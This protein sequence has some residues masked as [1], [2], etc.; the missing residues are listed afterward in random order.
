MVI[1]GLFFFVLYSY[2]GSKFMGLQYPW[3]SFL[4]NLED[5]F[6]DFFNINNMVASLDPYS[7]GSSYPPLALIFACLFAG[8]IPGT[9]TETAT[10]VKT[11]GR[12]GKWCIVALYAICL[13]ILV[14]AAWRR[15]WVQLKKDD[16]SISLPK[17][18]SK[19]RKMG[20]ILM[21]IMLFGFVAIALSSSAPVIFSF[22][23]GNYLILCVLF[24]TLFCLYYGQNDYVAATFLALAACLKIFPLVLFF[25]FFLHRKWKPLALGLFLGGSV[26]VGCAALFKRMVRLEPA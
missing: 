17:P 18:T 21:R 23:R 7:K 15:V 8:I 25:V 3:N 13:L 12:F 6:M 20:H 2:L 10:A 26:T 24:L 5:R 16:L 1:A 14:I 4:F 11:S 19:I 22:D 9:A